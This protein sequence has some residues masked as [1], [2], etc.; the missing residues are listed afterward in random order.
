MTL[1]IATLTA[2]AGLFLLAAC[3]TG[4]GAG[5][6]LAERFPPEGR[7]IAV[8]GT[9]LH[10]RE[11]GPADAEPVLVL[12]GASS[13]LNEPRVALE[14]ALLE[15]RVIWLDRPGLGWSERPDGDWSPER[16]AALIAA[17]LDAV[18]IE[19]AA[20]IGHSWGAAITLRLMMDHPDRTKGAVLIAPAVRA[21]VGEAAWYN[22]V[23]LWPVAGTVMTRAIAPTIGASRLAD[24]AAEAFSPEPVPENYVE[25]TRLPLIL[26]ASAW[27]ANA[28]DMANVNEHLAV[29]ETR[30]AEIDQPVILIAGPKDTVV[31]TRRHAVPVAETLPRGELVLVEGAGHNLHHHHP[32]RV[33]EALAAV[34]A[35]SE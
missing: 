12:H 15:Y 34:I 30:Y 20:V 29:Q 32:G 31:S 3:A 9:R 10:Y 21:W 33:A 27:R 4:A 16:E 28:A 5:R 1:L 19:R 25:R 35:R 2:G 24:G 23:T 18:G 26:R 6:T 13:N 7:F 22:R 11:T 8:E 17:F 14:D